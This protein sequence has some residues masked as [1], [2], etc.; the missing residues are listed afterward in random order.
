MP[1][2]EYVQVWCA[3]C[4]MY[5]RLSSTPVK[6]KEYCTDCVRLIK[7]AQAF[8]SNALPDLTKGGK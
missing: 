3:F 1:K 2:A 8:K 7:I 6:A 5:L 4:E